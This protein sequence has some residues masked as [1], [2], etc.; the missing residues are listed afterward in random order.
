MPHTTTVIIGAG[1]AGLAMSRRLTE[2]SID[3]VVL[4]RAEVANS[5]RTERWNSL[6]LLTPT[7]QNSLP[8][9]AGTADDPD[10][11]LTMPAVVDLIT[12]YASAIG[13]PVRTGTTVTRVRAASTG[14]EVTTDRGS[15]TSAAVVIASGAANIATVPD[16][17][18]DVPSGVATMSTMTYR[19]PEQLADSGVLVVGGS[20]SGVQLADEIRRS[21]RRVVLSMG[22]HVRLPRQYRG[23]DIFWWLDTIGLLDE[24]YDEMEDLARARRVPSPQLIGSVD[25]RS[26]DVNTLSDIGV[27]IVGRLGAIRAGVAQFSGGLQNQCALADLKMGR[28]LRRIDE[29]VSD[30]HCDDVERP[31][32]IESSHS[33][34]RPTLDMDLLQHD[35]GTI[36]WATGYRPD[37]SWLDIPVLDRRGR[38]VHDGGTVT[39]APGLYV[40]GTSLLRRRRSSYINGAATDTAELADHLQQHVR[41]T[42]PTVHA[43]VTR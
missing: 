1:H 26:I 20:A 19:C 2:R 8:G 43:Y 24:R 10:S 11:F 42:T 9:L 37:Y 27:E 3:H 39:A 14:F 23:R 38:L 31:Q 29:W 4:E 36:I 6:R 21:G 28:L 15:W 12:G 33:N 13:A 41:T 18:A 22:E 25:G 35:I 34:A 7:W 5:W 17:A 30:H 32:P 16:A 40:L